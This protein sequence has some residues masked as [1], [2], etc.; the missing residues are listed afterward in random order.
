MKLRGVLAVAVLVMSMSGCWLQA[1][2]GPSR[3]G[4][5]DLE[6]AITAANVAQLVPAWEGSLGSGFAAAPLVDSGVAYIRSD[7]RLSAFDLATGAA[8]WSV[9]VGAAGNRAGGSNA[10]PA[11]AGG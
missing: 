9:P 1:G 3:T 6:S 8:R 2:F 4:F 5:N 11:I 7:G 10:V